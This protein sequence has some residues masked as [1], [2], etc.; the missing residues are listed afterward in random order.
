MGE[1]LSGGRRKMRNAES[2]PCSML[3]EP[4]VDGET[5]PELPITSISSGAGIDL[6]TG[7]NSEELRGWTVPSGLI[8]VTTEEVLQATAAGY[9]LPA[10][11]LDV[12]RAAR[13]GASPGDLLS[14]LIS[15]WF[16]R[17]PALRLAEA[18]APSRAGTYVY[19]FA[20]R[21]PAFGGRL[22]ACHCAE[23][24][25]AFD[26]L[27]QPEN[28]P[29]LGSDP[30]QALADEVHRAWV[31]FVATGDPGWPQYQLD[32]RFVRRFG[33]RRRRS[34]T[35]AARSGACGRASAKQEPSLRRPAPEALP[36]G[37]R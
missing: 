21:S 7:T 18:H 20:W 9:R 34:R 13:P 6:L 17:L 25:F 37:R 16:F 26:T 11:A 4:V 36:A 5:L 30:P 8:D 2:R 22:G 32:R 29:L 33:T 24:A 1:A 23:I 31:S 19:E 15:D 27:E 14:A 12:Y 28:V 10:N 35:Q 3:F